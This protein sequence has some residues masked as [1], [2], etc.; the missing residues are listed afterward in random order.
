MET[1]RQEEKYVDVKETL[2]T[3]V[4]NEALNTMMLAFIHFY[5]YVQ[6][7]MQYNT[8]SQYQSKDIYPHALNIT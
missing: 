7:H 5:I 6:G 3:Q 8:Y 4:L 1:H 2:T